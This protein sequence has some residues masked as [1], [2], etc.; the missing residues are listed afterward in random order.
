MNQ[1]AKTAA[2]A[3]RNREPILRVL[4]DCLPSSALV[5]E[6]GSGTGEHAMWFSS[7]LRT[8]TWLP[9][10]QNPDAL[11]SIAAWRERA[12]LTNLLPPLALDA[13]AETW[14]VAHADVV[15]AINIVH[16]APWTTG[17][18][19]IAGAARVLA[20][21]GLLYLYGPFR[22]AGMHTAASNAAFDAELRVRDPS[23]GVRDLEE[24]TKFAISHGFEEPRKIAMPANNLSVVF[25]RR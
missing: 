13:S 23:W 21:G 18:G 17:Q 1:A 3:A 16:V 12:G 22:K 7:A 25:R 10:D 11:R 19:L 24:V 4:R 20:P 8:L 15:V 2:A 6:I 5:L 9:T 14:P